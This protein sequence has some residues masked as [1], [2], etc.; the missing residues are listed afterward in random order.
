MKLSVATKKQNASINKLVPKT[1][2][3]N[4]YITGT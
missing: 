1:V 3:S 2:A 4:M